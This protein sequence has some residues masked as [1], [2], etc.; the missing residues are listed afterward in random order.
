MRFDLRR[1]NSYDGRTRLR[2]VRINKSIMLCSAFQKLQEDAGKVVTL[3]LPLL[4]WTCSKQ[5]PSVYR[6]GSN[7]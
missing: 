7:P 6:H 3:E 5:P 1:K 2:D 4:Y